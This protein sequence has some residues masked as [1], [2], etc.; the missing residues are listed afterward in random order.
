V[1]KIFESVMFERFFKSSKPSK[2]IETK[3]NQ[4]QNGVK[5]C[6]EMSRN[7]IFKNISVYALRF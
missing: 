2:T 7:M 5:Q 4:V 6:F 1:K 3:Q